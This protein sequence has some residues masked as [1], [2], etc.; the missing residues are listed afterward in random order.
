MKT[1]IVKLG[2]DPKT[3]LEMHS[4]RYKG[5]PKSYLKVVWPMAQDVE[6]RFPGSTTPMGKEG[7][8][9]I[10]QAD[11]AGALPAGTPFVGQP[12]LAAFTPPKPPSVAKGMG[13]LAAFRPP[14]A[15]AARRRDTED[16][17]FSTRARRTCSPPPTRRSSTA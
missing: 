9:A 13:A 10:T 8:L 3:G 1:D 14:T 6:K 5:D 12:S 7:K 2:K 15:P 17:A 4:F 16:A 11:P